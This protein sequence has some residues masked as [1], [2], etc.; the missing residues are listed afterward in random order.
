MNRSGLA[1][2][3]GRLRPV[4]EKS[5]VRSSMLTLGDHQELRIL[6][7]ILNVAVRKKL[8]P[9]NPCAEA[10]SRLPKGL[11]PAALHGPGRAAEFQVPDDLRNIIRITAE[12]RSLGST[13]G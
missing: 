8:P 11:V 7:R 5:I 1:C 3:C 9:S 13:G 6:R 4:S 2:R 10:S 12:R